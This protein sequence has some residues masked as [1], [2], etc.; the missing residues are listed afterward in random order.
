MLPSF[1]QQADI[2][3]GKKGP[4]S[5]S[6][7]PPPLYCLSLEQG[8]GPQELKGLVCCLSKAPSPST[9][10]SQG[11]EGL[12]VMAP[13]ELREGEQFGQSSTARHG[14]DVT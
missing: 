5:L 12:G 14:R 6:L 11:P 4:L 10:S 8:T 2:T 1:F 13:L 9:Q 7:L 3:E